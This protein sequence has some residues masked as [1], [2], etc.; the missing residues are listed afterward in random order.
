MLQ[1]ENTKST[2]ELL[3][4]LSKMIIG[5]FAKFDRSHGLYK[6]AQGVWYTIGESARRKV[7]SRLL[8]VNHERY[9]EEQK[10]GAGETVKSAKGAKKK[11][12]K[13]A[14]EGQ[15]GLF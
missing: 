12:P 8:R 14:S 6:M 5:D 15:L 1:L 2:F 11:D 4:N 7:L 10:S 13:S 3:A 9:E